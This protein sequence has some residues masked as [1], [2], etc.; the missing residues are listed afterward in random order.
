MPKPSCLL[1]TISH[2]KSSGVSSNTV[3]RQFGPKHARIFATFRNLA[4]SET[5][6]LV[7]VDDLDHETMLLY[8]MRD[9]VPTWSDRR[10]DDETEVVQMH[11]IEM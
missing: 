8:E 6:Q 5:Q 2:G 11:V 3:P 1:A 7:L 9:A 4:D 10:R